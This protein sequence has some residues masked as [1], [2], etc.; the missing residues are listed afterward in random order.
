MKLYHLI[1]KETPIN[2][3]CMK[4]VIIQKMLKFLEEIGN[5]QLPKIER[6]WNTGKINEAIK[7]ILKECADRDVYYG[8]YLA[9]DTE[10][11]NE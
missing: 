10:E 7:I 6:L 11:V 2:S 4:L 1:W 8:D 3:S 9:E 5:K